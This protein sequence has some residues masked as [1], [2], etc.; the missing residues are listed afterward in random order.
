MKAAARAPGDVPSS[1]VKVLKVF[2]ELFSKSDRFPRI[3][4]PVSIAL[5]RWQTMI[6]ELWITRYRDLKPAMEK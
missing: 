1:R 5:Q 3:P 2:A 4:F 6:D